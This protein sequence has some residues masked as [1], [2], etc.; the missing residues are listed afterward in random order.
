MYKNY[1]INGNK[2]LE[3]LNIKVK[4]INTKEEIINSNNFV[5]TLRPSIK[6]IKI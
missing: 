4:D 2:I 6:K 5:A 1:L 3:K